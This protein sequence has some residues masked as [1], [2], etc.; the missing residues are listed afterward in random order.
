METATA[1][2]KS[3]RRKVVEDELVV[4]GKY[5]CMQD[6]SSFLLLDSSC[7]KDLL[8][9][10]FHQEGYLLFRDFFDRHEVLSARQKI[11][12]Y[13]DDFYQVSLDQ[14]EQEESSELES[15]QLLNKQDLAHSEEVLLI[16]ENERIFALFKLLF[17]KEFVTF[18]Y[19]VRTG[20]I[21]V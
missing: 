13:L 18:D 16:L 15:I 9:Q 19:K 14:L 5:E 12:D 21:S 10:R 11:R 6:S 1:E 4:E 8:L 17:E 20:Y 3:K 2:R 7:K